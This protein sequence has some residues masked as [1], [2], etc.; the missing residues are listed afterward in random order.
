[1]AYVKR[2]LGGSAWTTTTFISL[3]MNTMNFSHFFF[4]NGGPYFLF[5]NIN[6]KDFFDFSAVPALIPPADHCH[7]SGFW[8]WTHALWRHQSFGGRLFTIQHIYGKFAIFS[9]LIGFEREKWKW[10]LESRTQTATIFPIPYKC[11]EP[12]KNFTKI[13]T[14]SSQLIDE[15]RPSIICEIVFIFFFL[16]KVFKLFFFHFF[17]RFSFGCGAILFESFVKLDFRFVQ[18]CQ[19]FFNVSNFS[20]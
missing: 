4:Q 16:S 11:Q 5:K 7:P 18:N 10:C 12:V 17:L 6:R 15:K 19:Q 14:Y 2:K 8:C 13:N 1:M 9:E 3:K 20:S